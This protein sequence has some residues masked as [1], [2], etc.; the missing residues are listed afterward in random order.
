MFEYTIEAYNNS[1][2]FNTN[3]IT[4]TVMANTPELAISRAKKIEARE[5]YAVVAIRDMVNTDI[6]KK[7]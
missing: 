4:I 7:G 3:K 6:K 1:S 5:Q 2:G